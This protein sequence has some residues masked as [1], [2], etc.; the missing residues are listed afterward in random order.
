MSRLDSAPRWRIVART[1]A[2]MALAIALGASA[3]AQAT[4][5]PTAPAKDYHCGA[6]ISAPHSPPLT[7]QSCVIVH[8]GYVQGAV[9]ITNSTDNPRQVSRPTGYT[10]V[11]LDNK[12]YRND[13]CGPTTLAGRQT[14]FCYGKTTLIPGQHDVFATGYVWT[15]TGVHDLVHSRHSKTV[16]APPPPPS[17]GRPAFVAPWPCGQA[18]TYLSLIHI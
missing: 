6:V 5:S 16:P 3:S 13:N 10:R 8:G 12:P 15:G 18:R 17:G 11:W 7:F 9:K 14:K 4:W 1:A 2:P